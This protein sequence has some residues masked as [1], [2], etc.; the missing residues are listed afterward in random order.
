MMIVADDD[1]DDVDDYYFDITRYDKNDAD[2]DVIG[3]F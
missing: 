1:D 3:K 2:A